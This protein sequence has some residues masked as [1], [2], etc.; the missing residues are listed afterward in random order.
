VE[1]IDSADSEK[2]KEEL[3][4]LL[5]EIIFCGE[6]YGR[7][8][9]FSIDD[10]ADSIGRKMIERHP[11]VFGKDRLSTPREVQESWTRIKARGSRDD[12]AFP[13]SPRICLHW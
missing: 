3:G 4:D 10:A 8:G 12:S 9:A 7:A 2:I 13:A 1:A 11:H 5:F 6:D